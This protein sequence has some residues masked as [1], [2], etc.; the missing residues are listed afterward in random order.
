MALPFSRPPTLP[1]GFTMS[2]CTPADVQ[3][4]NEVCDMDAFSNTEYTYWWG[5]V[6]AMWT[7]QEERIR[8]RFA[9][10]S[11]QQFKV[12]DDANGTIVAWAKWDPPSQMV[13]LREG[14]TAYDESGETV[15]AGAGDKNG[16]EKENADGK[17]S[18]KSYALGP[19]EGSNV[20]LFQEFYD[21]LI[22][23]EKK[24]HTSE[25][26]V[27]THLCTRHS[28]HGRGIGS[29]L[30]RGVLD[31]ADEEG[32]L[33]YLEATLLA[34]PVYQR[35]GYKIVDTLE[36]DRTDAGLGTPVIL[37]VMVREPRALT[38]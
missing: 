15:S 11:T 30:L 25:K 17:M 31:L 28:Y 33:A 26:L 34:T 18:A 4:M 23:A 13:G 10:P 5:P 12:V 16:E 20:A 9:D 22:G 14:F 27:L 37:H 1:R 29:A 6:P 35:L 32:L 36:F 19:P 7:W 2:R 8:R 24:F 38:I 21:G 3:G